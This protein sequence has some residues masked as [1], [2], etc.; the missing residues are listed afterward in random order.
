VTKCIGGDLKLDDPEAT[1]DR[2]GSSIP[3]VRLPSYN[4]PAQRPECG[5]RMLPAETN[6][7]RQGT[8]QAGEKPDKTGGDLEAG[9]ST[10]ASTLPA[11]T[12]GRQDPTQAVERPD[13]AGGDPGADGS[14][15][16]RC[17]GEG[18]EANNSEQGASREQGA[19]EPGLERAMPSNK[20]ENKS[21][22]QPENGWPMKGNGP[23]KTKPDIFAW[24]DAHRRVQ[25]KDILSWG[26]ADR[27]K[28]AS[29]KQQPTDVVSNTNQP[30]QS[31]DGSVRDAPVNK[32]LGS[33]ATNAQNQAHTAPRHESH[34]AQGPCFE[35]LALHQVQ[36]EIKPG[37][38][39]LETRI[40]E[41]EEAEGKEEG[42]MRGVEVQERHM[43]DTCAS[44]MW[45]THER[46]LKDNDP[47]L[48]ELDLSSQDLGDDDAISLA[49]SLIGADP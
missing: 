38:E 41:R 28:T 37:I 47:T 43:G 35:G 2:K 33:E 21:D 29:S 11:A 3:D 40:G 36:V 30:S 46:R 26:D 12:R 19:W 31:E 17:S 15:E 48:T 14:K 45:Y 4:G 24:S 18:R 39:E 9:G 32:A 22:K 20:S 7:E 5:A 16:A 42:G 25:T 8:T 23:G 10:E 13:R 1:A 49:S 44:R 6:R 34:R 27:Q